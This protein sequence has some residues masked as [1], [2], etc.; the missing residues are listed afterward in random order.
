[1]AQ[2]CTL[3]NNSIIITESQAIVSPEAGEVDV[4]ETLDITGVFDAIGL[5]ASVGKTI[6]VNENGNIDVEGSMIILGEVFY[7]YFK[8]DSDTGR[9][10]QI[11]PVLKD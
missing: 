7:T 2:N 5:K 3:N 1:M 9:Y 11:N 6:R 8:L 10:Q 4:L